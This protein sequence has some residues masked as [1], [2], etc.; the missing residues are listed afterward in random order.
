[1]SALNYTKHSAQN[2]AG[3]MRCELRVNDRKN[4]GLNG[5]G[6]GCETRLSPAAGV[7]SPRREG[8]VGAHPEVQVQHPG[9]P[10]GLFVGPGN[11]YINAGGETC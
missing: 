8:A 1:M 2:L 9:L 5:N 4:H 10:T 6:E 3:L 11:I 7:V